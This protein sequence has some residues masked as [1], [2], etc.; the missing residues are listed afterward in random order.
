M[1]KTMKPLKISQIHKKNITDSGSFCQNTA[2]GLEKPRGHTHEA[3]AWTHEA[4]A[5]THEAEAWTHEAEASNFGLEVEAR[6][7][8]TR[9]RSMFNLR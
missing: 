8:I 6:P 5:W 3:E 4:E 2:A 1:K 9:S 7:N